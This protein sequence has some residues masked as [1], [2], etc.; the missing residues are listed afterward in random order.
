MP[1]VFPAPL[2]LLPL[3]GFLTSGATLSAAFELTGELPATFG[4]GSVTVSRETLE[5]RSLRTVATGRM[6]AGR[7]N[8][9]VEEEPGLFNVQ[10]G[11]M[12]VS[13]VADHG[14]TL[15]VRPAA[16]EQAISVTGSADQELYAAYEK[17]RTESLAR[18]VLPVRAAIGRSRASGNDAEVERLTE[19]EISA[20]REHRHELN[21]FT[22]AQLPGSVAL[23]PASLRWDGDYRLEELAATVR[24]FAAARPQAAI[25]RRLQE[26]IARFHAT[27]LGAIAPDLTGPTPDGGTVALAALRGKYVLVDFWA[28]WCSPCR[29][30][31][32]HYAELYR[33]FRAD[34]FEILAVSVDQNEGAW[35]TAITADDAQW[36]HLSDLTGWQSPI[37]ARYNVTALP[38]SFLLDPTGRIIAKDAR[39]EPLTRLLETQLGGSR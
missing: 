37:A 19:Q 20:Y 14:Q 10:V 5:D 4:N 3:L 15:H 30:E 21:D 32:R 8:L 6:S 2:R 17:L 36:L 25:A 39:G 24:D 35:K 18:L 23:Y 1:L 7:F 27:A 13:F 16:G 12:Q 38:A 26:R 28:S 11:D 9:T 33:R 34:G 29:I 22:L 31:N